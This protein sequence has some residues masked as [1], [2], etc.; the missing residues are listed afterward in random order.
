[1]KRVIFFTQNRWA[2][3][4][5]HHGL[6]KEL[7]KF[8]ILA[9][10]LDWTQK[11][12]AEEFHLLNQTYDVFVT[13]PEA[14]LPLHYSGIPLNKI[15]TVA[16]GQWD[17]L[18]A[19]RD[20]GQDFYNHI[21]NFAVVSNILREKALEFGIPRV[22]VVT[23]F[24]IHFDLYC[25]SPHEQLKTIG[26]GGAKETVNFFGKEIKRGLLV[27]N[28]VAQLPTCQLLEHQFYNWMCMPAYYKTVDCV[29][30]SS[31]EESAGIPMMEAAASGRL[32]IGTPVGYFEQHGPLG[33]GVVLPVDDTQFVNGLV[34]TLNHYQNSPDLYKIK[35]Q[36]IQEYARYHYDWQYHIEH[37]VS[38]LS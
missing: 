2:F 8:G 12:T 23:T 11:Y 25:D 15:I 24:G 33:G 10:L 36:Q 13:N 20:S 30:Q 35:C 31:S 3:A 28:A 16:H 27:R 34:Q 17:M 38:L 32:C 1:M 5:I 22:P 18:L 21:K 29:I 19:R 37:W 26:Y 4:N 14:V 9:N 6:S 7:Y